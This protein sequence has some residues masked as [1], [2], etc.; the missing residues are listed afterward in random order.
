MPVTRVDLVGR[1][2][3]ED[4]FHDPVGALVAIVIR[5]L[6]QDA[7]LADERVVAAPGV[8]ADAVDR[9]AGSALDAPACISSQSRED[10]PVERAVLP[11]RLVGEAVD[12]LTSS[13]PARSR[14]EHGTAALGSEIERQKV[15]ASGH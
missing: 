7:L 11:H 9:R 4:G 1:N 3:L 6:E 10:I 13:T 2:A 14:A 5:V 8:D 12:S 15:S